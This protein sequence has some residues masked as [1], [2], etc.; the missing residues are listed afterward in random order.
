MRTNRYLGNDGKILLLF[1][2]AAGMRSLGKLFPR[3]ILDENAPAVL[4]KVAIT[5]GPIFWS[6]TRRKNNS[7]AAGNRSKD[8]AI[9]HAYDYVVYNKDN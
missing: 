4:H 5:D 6:Q 8:N 3:L 1:S 2:L 7:L 9:N